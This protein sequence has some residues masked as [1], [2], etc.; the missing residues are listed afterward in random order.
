MEK[1]NN[2]TIQDKEKE[3][4]RILS[5]LHDAFTEKNQLQE[6]LHDLFIGYIQSQDLDVNQK[7]VD[8]YLQIR[9]VLQETQKLFN[10]EKESHE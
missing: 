7:A 2:K 10:S 4:Y 6:S 3:A 1:S 5:E 8:S 9:Y